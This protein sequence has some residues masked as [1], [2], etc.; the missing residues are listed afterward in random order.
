MFTLD[1]T[2]FNGFQHLMPGSQHEKLFV[3]LQNHS[4]NEEFLSYI[5]VLGSRH[6]RFARFMFTRKKSGEN[7]FA[8]NVMYI[9]ARYLY[10]DRLDKNEEF[11]YLEKLFNAADT[12]GITPIAV[13][14]P[15]NIDKCRF[16]C[17]DAFDEQFD[18]TVTLVKKKLERNA[19]NII[20]LSRILT[21]EYFNDDT[22]F[23][24]AYNCA[25][26]RKV[27]ES[28]VDYWRKMLPALPC[29]TGAV[30]SPTQG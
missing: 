3:E 20:D 30:K 19:K 29:S 18:K 27:C 7:S 21:A 1:V 23:D 26:R 25:G 22:T 24:E 12:Y 8:E 10:Q 2:Q 5:K 15:V 13:I 16:Y 28:I 4:K 9:K 14:M 11:F 17:N 6:R